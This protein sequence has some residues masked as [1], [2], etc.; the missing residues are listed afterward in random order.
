LTIGGIKLHPTPSKSAPLPSELNFVFAI[1]QRMLHMKCHIRIVEQ[2]GEKLSQ[3]IL[4]AD[5]R[6][7]Q[8]RLVF[9]ILGKK[10]Q[11]PLQIPRVPRCAPC[12]YGFFR[13][14][15]EQA[16]IMPVFLANAV[17]FFELFSYP[18]GFRFYFVPL[19]ACT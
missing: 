6:G 12:C 8:M 10:G 7:K 18:T 16:R 17:S 2:T 5:R 11:Q 15:L 14:Q 9:A 3:V 19:N 13:I 4:S 1:R